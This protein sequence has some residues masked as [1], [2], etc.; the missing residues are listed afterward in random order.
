MELINIW[1]MLNPEGQV[2]VPAHHLA[3]TTLKD[4]H[5]ALH[6]FSFARI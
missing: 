3:Q 4:G 1:E 5:I 6:A 2:Q